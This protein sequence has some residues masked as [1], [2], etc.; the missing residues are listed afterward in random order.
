MIDKLI[1]GFAYFSLVFLISTGG[2]FAENIQIQICSELS[3]QETDR[4]KAIIDHLGIDLISEGDSSETSWLF[5]V[6]VGAQQT[7][8]PSCLATQVKQLKERV[9]LERVVLSKNIA[10]EN[11]YYVEGDESYVSFQITRI[12]N[13][14]YRLLILSIQIDYFEDHVDDI[15]ARL[16][17]FYESGSLK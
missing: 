6:A 2:S 1:A 11:P 14:G 3:E 9:A 4:L 15:R 13:Y 16:K 10:K 8:T 7:V 17:K 5:Y 12:K